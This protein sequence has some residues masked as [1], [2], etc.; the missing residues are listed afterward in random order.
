MHSYC[1]CIEGEGGKAECGDST[2]A[3]RWSCFWSGLWRLKKV[4]VWWGREWLSRLLK[5]GFVPKPPIMEYR[6]GVNCGYIL[7]NGGRWSWKD[8]KVPLLEMSLGFWASE[9]AGL[10]V[11]AWWLQ[12]DPRSSCKGDWRELTLQSCP[13]ASMHMPWHACSYVCADTHT[14]HLSREYHRFPLESW[15][16]Q[17]YSEEDLSLECSLLKSGMNIKPQF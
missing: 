1:N 13:S 4:C 5:V 9:A 11:G 7:G 6:D 10:A 17:W 2:A 16:W 15:L 12:L 8:R 14:K 3:W